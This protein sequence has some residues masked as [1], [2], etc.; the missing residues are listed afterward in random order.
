MP[1]LSWSAL[2]V[3]NYA[4]SHPW[5]RLAMVRALPCALFT[6]ASQ[7]RQ[8]SRLPN[9]VFDPFNDPLLKSSPIEMTR[10]TRED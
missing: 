6:T 3:A 1:T 9:V 10:F 4:F 8:R 2:Y 5:R 7:A